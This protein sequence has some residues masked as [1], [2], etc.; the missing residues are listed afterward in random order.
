M[1]DAPDD[2]RP[3]RL[4]LCREG[5]ARFAV[6]GYEA[7]SHSNVRN[8]HM[9]LTNYSINRKADGFKYCEDP[10]GGH[11]S[12]RTISSVFRSLQRA[13][14]IG[15]VE[16]LWQELSRLVSRACPTGVI[17]PG[18][19]ASHSCVCMHLMSLRAYISRRCDELLLKA[20]PDMLLTGYVWHLL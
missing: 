12:K 17:Q 19:H 9:H 10:D 8:I 6:E 15:D 1:Q 20:I 13:G 5:L 16:E 4:F 18:V 14:K 3:M 11:G 7:P 2:G